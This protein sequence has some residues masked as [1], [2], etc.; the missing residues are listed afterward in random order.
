MRRRL[1][2][3]LSR[4]T[5]VT[6]RQPRHRCACGRA[7]GLDGEC[8]ACREKRLQRRAAEKT[9]GPAVPPSVQ[10]ALA[11]PGQPLDPATR[12]FME[13]RFGHDFSRVRVHTDS[14]AV[15]SAG[16]VNALAYTVGRDVVFGVGQYAPA[17]EEGKRLLAHELSH[18]VQQS[19]AAHGNRQA[20]EAEAETEAEEKSRRM[21][22]G[23]S[24]RVQ[25]RVIAGTVQRQSNKNP[26][27]EKAKAI[28]A[29]AQ[30]EK[31]KLE[32]RA[33]QVVKAIIKQYYPSEESKVAAV[34]YNDKEAGTGLSVTSKGSGK[35]TTGILY[36]GKQFLEGVTARHF[37]RRVLQVGHE[38][39]HINQ[40]RS[41][42][43]GGSKQNEREFLAFYHEAL[44]TEKPGTG[45]MQHGTR[46]NLIDAALGYYYCLSSEKQKQYAT[47]KK[48][49]LERRPK[50]VKASGREA[51]EP[52]TACKRQ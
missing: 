39:E 2:T 37:A 14:M 41:G 15:A 42:L 8:E 51:G 12:A 34:E 48:E 5:S 36:V 33:V 18:V 4:R 22:A 43:A 6:T 35:T 25:T 32:E 29:Q 45:R 28:I 9:E 30:N 26:L 7:A 47:N 17:T 1:Q 49:L 23:E 44:A 50:E 21:L 19:G 16:A 11:L 27:D 13:P 20:S 3:D 40:Y 24:S 52:P 38:L 46:V 10:E 31:I